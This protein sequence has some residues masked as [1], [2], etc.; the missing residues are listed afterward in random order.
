MSNSYEL[1]GYL[2]VYTDQLEI[3]N[4][5]AGICERSESSNTD[6]K[7]FESL[8][9]SSNLILNSTLTLALPSST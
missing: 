8:N 4:L 7:S 1:L 3:F 2:L 5:L 9:F 6:T